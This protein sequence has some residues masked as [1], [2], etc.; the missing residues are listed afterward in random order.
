[1]KKNRRIAWDKVLLNG[2]GAVVLLIVDIICILPFVLLISAS[3]SSEQSI[4]LEGFSLIP[5]EFSLEA[6]ETLFRYPDDVFRAFGV[7]VFVTA[8]ESFVGLICTSM[9]AYVMNRKDF[10]YRNVFSFYFY[11]VTLFSGGMVATYIII[12]KY[13][14]LKDN[15]LALIMPLMINAFYLIIM[16]S[17]MS[18]IPDSLCESAKV[19]GAGDFVIFSK[20]ILPLIKPALAIVGLFLVLDYWN[21]W[22]NAM[23]YISD[24]KWY[25]LQY[26]L[27]NLISAQD[28]LA[29]MADKLGVSLMNMPMQS[30][31]MAMTV[32]TMVPILLVYPCVK[33]YF[34]AGITVGAV[35]G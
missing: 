26:L 28:A 24:K 35:K 13:Y 23:L 5:N 21:D 34:V 20:I 4:L 17:F 10:K 14:H 18:N 15:I 29:R 33:K 27:Y 11:F 2:I 6:Y 1:M 9:A 3:F 31:K 25:P 16:R 32:V 30:L 19:D 8:S 22:Y 12:I 7:S